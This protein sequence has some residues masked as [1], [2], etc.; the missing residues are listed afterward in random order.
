[1]KK[2]KDLM[3]RHMRKVVVLKKK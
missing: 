1:M 2:T 3:P